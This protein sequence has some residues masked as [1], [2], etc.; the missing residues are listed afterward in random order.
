MRPVMLLARF[1][2]KK[3]PCPAIVLDDEEAE[4]QPRQR[5]GQHKRQP[6]ADIE[7]QIHCR[8]DSREGKDG[9]RD[10]APSAKK[11]RTAIKRAVGRKF[12]DCHV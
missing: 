8:R 11:A 4:R 10:L 7:A 9:G 5:D 12:L 1:E 2:A 6:V 3:E